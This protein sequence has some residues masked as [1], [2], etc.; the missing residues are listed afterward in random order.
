[1]TREEKLAALYQGSTV[2]RPLGEEDS[3]LA[4]LPWDAAGAN[5]PSAILPEIPSA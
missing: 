5:A 2:Y 4:E 3:I 1:M